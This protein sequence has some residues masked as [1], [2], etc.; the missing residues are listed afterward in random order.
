[1]ADPAVVF[2]IDLLQIMGG[3]GE[4]LPAPSRGLNPDI[5]NIMIKLCTL[6]HQLQRIMVMMFTLEEY[7]ENKVLYNVRFGCYS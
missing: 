6:R 3:G 5:Y 4:Y 1:M 2:G 7:E